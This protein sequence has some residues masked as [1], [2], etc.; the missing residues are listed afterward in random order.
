[1]SLGSVLMV[2]ASNRF[3]LL[4][5]RPPRTG[6]GIALHILLIPH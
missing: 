5:P 3:N 1:M 2:M 4:Q 6:A